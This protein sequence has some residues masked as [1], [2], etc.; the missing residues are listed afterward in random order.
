MHIRDTEILPQPRAV[1]PDGFIL[2]KF[3]VS[4]DGSQPAASH[5]LHLL[6]VNIADIDKKN[7]TLAL[8]S[9]KL[10]SFS[11]PVHELLGMWKGLES[12]DEYISSIPEILQLKR[13]LIS[14]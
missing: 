4:G 2:A 3:N 1:V 14:F 10:C 6:S 8:A 13:T 7:S 11:I 12:T 5:T 9:Q